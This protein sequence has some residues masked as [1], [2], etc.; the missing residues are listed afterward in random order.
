MRH[1]VATCCFVFVCGGSPYYL[2]AGTQS[3][4]ADT[5][6]RVVS[7]EL[8]TPVVETSRQIKHGGRMGL[9]FP[10]PTARR[11][12]K[13]LIEGRESLALGGKLELRLEAELS[14]SAL[15]EQ[16]LHSALREVDVWKTTAEAQAKEL[17]ERASPPWYKRSHTLAILGFFLG[18]G[19]TALI[20]WSLQR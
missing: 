4:R 14:K 9:W 19:S 5:K 18:A 7:S 3:A 1:L 13:D 6:P 20:A 16:Q 8:V 12:L 15:L 17:S 2:G 11:L 10:M